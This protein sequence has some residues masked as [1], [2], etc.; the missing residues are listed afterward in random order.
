[1]KEFPGSPKSEADRRGRLLN[2]IDTLRSVSQDEKKTYILM[3][4]DNAE[5]VEAWEQRQGLTPQELQNWF[6]LQVQTRILALING[7]I[8]QEKVSGKATSYIEANY[9]QPS[10]RAELVSVACAYYEGRVEEA[11]NKFRGLV[12]RLHKQGKI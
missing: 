3:L 7:Y 2:Y 10:L 11:R 5:L 12:D 9:K 8:N 4:I 1:M 6:L